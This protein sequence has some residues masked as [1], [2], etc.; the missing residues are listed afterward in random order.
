VR[1]TPR[2]RGR[3]YGEQA[4]DRVLQC[5]RNYEATFLQKG[6]AW[7]RARKLAGEFFPRIEAYDAALADE[8]RGIAEGAAVGL[9]EVVALNSRTEL[10]Y[11]RHGHRA[12]I[13][14][15]DDEGCTGAIALPEVTAGGHL[16]HGQNWDWRDEAGDACV[17]LRATPDE[18]PPFLCFVEAGMLARAGMNAAGM[19]VTGNF[20]ECQSDGQRQGI[21]LPLIRRQVLQSRGLGPAIQAVCQAPRMFS[22]NLMVS[23]SGG[24]AIDLETTPDEVFWIAPEGGLLVHANHFVSAAA[25]ARVVDTGLRTNGD[26]LYRDR[27]VHRLLAADRGEIS[28]E[29]FKRAFQ[30]RYGSPRAVCRTPAFG[31][32]GRTSSTVATVIMDT[33]ELRM[34]IAPRPYGPHEYTEYRL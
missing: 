24:E 26:S 25:R 20:L 21:P 5:I 9:E 1:G 27:R 19:A 32:G 4:R 23:H 6:V 15:P 10:M 16:I 17:V 13:D 29:T 14:A 3:Q 30:D 7:E 33:T 8:I 28:V 18:G 31:P 2:E 22:N 34:W 12:G 11:G